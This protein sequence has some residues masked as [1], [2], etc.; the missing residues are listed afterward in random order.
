[1]A[2]VYY[3]LI[4]LICFVYTRVF[5]IQMNASLFRSSERELLVIPPFSR[6]EDAGLN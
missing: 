2:N 3:Q 5:I 4:F 6:E 1:M